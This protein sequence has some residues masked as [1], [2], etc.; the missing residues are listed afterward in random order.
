M[1]VSRLDEGDWVHAPRLPLGDPYRGV[2]C[3]E[4]SRSFHPPESS[5]RDVCN[6]GYARGRCDRFPGD[7]PGDAIR[8]SITGDDGARLRLTFIVEKD[9]APADHGAIEGRA[10]EIQSI[11]L[12]ENDVMS[13]QARAF[14]E[15]YLRRRP[16]G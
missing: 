16:V 5:Q 14:L 7:S 6:H 12:R 8:F 10:E 9:H 2:C 4:P 1:P 11:R 13:G 3:S 15:S